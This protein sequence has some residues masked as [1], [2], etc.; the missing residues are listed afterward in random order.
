MQLSIIKGNI[1]YVETDAIVLPA[2]R[3]LREGPGTSAAIF[4]AADQTQLSKDCDELIKEHG[5]YEVGDVVPTY[6]YNLKAVFILHAIVPKWMDG[7]K[8][9]Y[10]DLCATYLT[11]LSVADQLECRSVAFP[12]LASGNNGYDLNLAFEIARQSIETFQGENLKE[13]ILVIRGERIAEIV[14]QRGYEFDDKIVKKEHT[15]YTKQIKETKKSNIKIYFDK[16]KDFL[17]NKENR[18]K[19]YDIAMEIVTF[20]R[21]IKD[22]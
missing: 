8:N 22:E 11:A 4:E 15:N 13:V 16:V 17:G 20:A 6:A 12:L 2:N 10:E 3:M 5:P 18:E 9:E 21:K 14:H 1:V 19:I 7:T